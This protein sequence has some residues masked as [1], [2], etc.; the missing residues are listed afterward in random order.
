MY[1]QF[2]EDTPLDR[3][4]TKGN[5]YKNLL[6]MAV[7]TM[8]GFL[9][10]TL[11]DIVD[12]IWIGRISGLAVA[13]VT[14]IMTIIW[15][16]DVV[17]EVIGVSS[18]SLISQSYGRGDYKESARAIG[19]TI[20]F[21]MVIAAVIAVFLSI[22]LKPIA[23]IFTNDTQTLQYIYDYGYIRIATLPILFALFSIVTALRNIGESKKQMIIMTGSAVV[24]IILD[25]IMMFDVVPIIGIKG[26]GLGVFGA[27]L[28]TV[29]SNVLAFGLGMYYL[30]KG[31]SRIKMKVKDFI[32]LDWA[33]DY[34]LLTIGL[35]M[36]VENLLR[37]FS[38][39]IVLKLVAGYGPEVIA[40][41]GIGNRIIGFLM[42]PLLGL[43]MGGSTIVGQNLGKGNVDRSKST[44]KISALFGMSVMIVVTLI[45]FSFPKE[46]MKIFVFEPNIIQMGI[47]MVKIIV[48]SMIFSAVSFGI[49]ACFMG[50]GYNFPY[51][52]SSIVSKWVFQIPIMFYILKTYPESPNF[53]WYGFLV[54]SIVEMGINLYYYREG[55]WLKRRV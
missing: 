32:T 13:S 46:I 31:N 36:G 7:P 8:F 2:K 44:A 28:A 43:S 9:S 14:I 1:V 54:A 35:P 52:V 34:K 47:P 45:S 5:V 20:F 26:F 41:M 48:F 19:Q 4:L 3:D 49:S 12:L 16:T 6:Y 33:M 53:I 29:I 37:N 50:S 40:V 11:Y 18:I 27:A 24:N 22:F 23:K 55:T 10:Q 42:M 25:P 15:L 39:L 51:S 21:K 38:A 17:N 30:F